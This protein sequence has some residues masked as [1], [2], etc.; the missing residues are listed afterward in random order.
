MSLNF[1]LSLPREVRD[2]IFIY[3]LSSPTGYIYTSICT[4]DRKHFALLPFELPNCVNP[5]RIR[6]SLLQTCKQIYQEAKDVVYEQ[7]TWAVLSPYHILS[8]FQELDAG[9]SHRVRN[10]WLGVNLAHR[11]G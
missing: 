2:Q 6:L 10:I 7:N 8:Q 9:L 5:G 3:A 11:Y 1:I 4:A